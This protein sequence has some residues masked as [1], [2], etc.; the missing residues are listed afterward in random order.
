M[1]P[2]TIVQ[3]LVTSS[4][5]LSFEALTVVCLQL[6]NDAFVLFQAERSASEEME[7]SDDMNAFYSTPPNVQ[8]GT[9]TYI[10]KA[11]LD[12]LLQGD[13]SGVP[14]DRCTLS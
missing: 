8:R 11:V 5:V 4:H 1:L 6:V 12:L 3:T 10:A 2:L 9:T 13:I 7:K 14:D